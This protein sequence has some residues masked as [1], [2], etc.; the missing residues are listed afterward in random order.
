MQDF[1]SRYSVGEIKD[2][3]DSIKAFQS[4]LRKLSKR[5]GHIEIQGT[6]EQLNSLHDSLLETN[7]F[8]AC[9]CIHERNMW[10]HEW[11]RVELSDLSSPTFSQASEFIKTKG[12]KAYDKAV[13][14]SNPLSVANQFMT[15]CAEY[16]HVH[17][18]EPYRDSKIP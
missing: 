10:L 1:E 6:Q 7:R 13:K 14:S 16:F 15:D 9:L 17:G 2:I 5:I 11:I 3:K 4:D 8:L 18:L 12:E